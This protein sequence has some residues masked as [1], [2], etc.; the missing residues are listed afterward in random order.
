[1]MW[2]N[3]GRFLA[4]RQVIVRTPLVDPS[5]SSSD[6]A[7]SSSGAEDLD[8][9]FTV[10]TP[11]KT[12]CALGIARRDRFWGVAKPLVVQPPSCS[13]EKDVQAPRL[14]HEVSASAKHE[15]ASSA[16]TKHEHAPQ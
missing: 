11:V 5:I 8:I 4:P 6:P 9:D 10:T 16:N 2:N 14:I 13:V 3:A 1:M 15:H 12:P 7:S